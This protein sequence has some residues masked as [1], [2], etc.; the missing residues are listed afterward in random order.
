[1]LIATTN[2][3]WGKRQE[4]RKSKEREEGIIGN[5]NEGEW[6]EGRKELIGKKKGRGG[7]IDWDV[8]GVMR[9]AGGIYLGQPRNGEYI[10]SEEGEW[11]GNGIVVFVGDLM[12]TKKWQQNG[13]RDLRGGVGSGE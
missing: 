6:K 8:E 7:G 9:K 12:M 3:A 13:R 4:E 11:N 10:K 2:I 1:L 5:G